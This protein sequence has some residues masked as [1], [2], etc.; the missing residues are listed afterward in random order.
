[1]RLANIQFEFLPDGDD[2][3]CCRHGSRRAL[4]RIVPDKVYPSM[5][6]IVRADGTLSGMV[7]L[8]R[9]KDAAWGLAERRV[10]LGEDRR[11]A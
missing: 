3:K 2:L 10:F 7:N 1:M 8:A 5:W 6:R 9:A 11:A 4:V